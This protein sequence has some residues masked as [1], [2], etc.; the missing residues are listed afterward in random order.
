MHLMRR[1]ALFSACAVIAILTVLPVL[2]QFIPSVDYQANGNKASVTVNQ[3]EAIIFRESNAGMSPLQR[4]KL[5]SERLRPLAAGGW[6]KISVKVVGK[7]RAQV[8]VGHQLICVATSAD[9]KAAQTSAKTLAGIW[10]SNLRHLFAMPALTVS[11][12]EIT[13]PENENRIVVIGG[14]ATGPLDAIDTNPLATSS[15]VASGRRAIVVK[16]KA[17]GRSTVL[18]KCQGC[19]TNFSVSVKRYAGKVTGPGIVEVTGDPAPEWIIS[20]AAKRAA[21]SSFALEPGATASIGSPRIVPDTL[22]R[23]TKTRVSV[24]VTV[25]GPNL[26]TR[27][28]LAQVDVVNRS[29]TDKPADDLFYSNNPE[30]ITHNGVL[31][32]GKLNLDSRTRLFFHHQN[33]SGE[34][35]RFAVELLNAGNTPAMV[36]LISGTTSPLV[37]TVAVGYYAGLNFIRDYMRHAG[38]IHRI[39]PG[40]RLIVYADDLDM[41][42]TVSGIID[43]RELSGED[44]Y[45]RVLAASPSAGI[46]EG[47]IAPI[48]DASIP[49]KLSSHVYTAPVQQLDVQYVVGGQWAFIRIGKYGISDILNQKELYGNYGVIYRINVTIENP[50]GDKKDV[51]IVFEPTAGPASGIF[52]VNGSI[53]G[54]KTVLPPLEFEIA[55]ITVQPGRTVKLSIMTIPLGGSA[56][57][58]TIIVR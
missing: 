45:V 29:V 47:D 18:V 20:L 6:K 22:D 55:R 42:R 58:A 9:A 2:G 4:A 35:V 56:Y 30:R 51:H 32:A 13:V 23:G 37:D 57:P 3:R 27:E 50:T 33:M 53:I 17:V 14:A 41:K 28:L 21:T 34:R 39:P 1:A 5:T 48:T 10:A 38:I 15:S 31:F 44:V 16:G 11:A 49:S 40:S 25:K 54:T 36:Q 46:R 52:V 26:I 8:V 7:R 19:T 43:M 24:P 12:K